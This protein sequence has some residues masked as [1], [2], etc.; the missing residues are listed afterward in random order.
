MSWVA[1]ASEEGP[2]GPRRSELIKKAIRKNFPMH[3]G[4][5]DIPGFD[6][7]RGISAENDFNAKTY[8]IIGGIR[9]LFGGKLDVL[10][11]NKFYALFYS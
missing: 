3:G 10:L 1:G 8:T 11:K 4:S 5:N 9:S 7:C 2:E 6:L